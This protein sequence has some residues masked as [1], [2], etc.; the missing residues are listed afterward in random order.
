[1]KIRVIWN[2]PDSTTATVEMAVNDSDPSKND[3]ELQLAKAIA[4]A[5][6]HFNNKFAEYPAQGQLSATMI[7]G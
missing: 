4:A 3:H 7:E 5:G 2:R 1:M 6:V